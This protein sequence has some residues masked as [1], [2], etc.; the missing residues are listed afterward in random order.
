MSGYTKRPCKPYPSMRTISD[1][2]VV[3]TIPHRHIVAAFQTQSCE[4]S[5]LVAED[6]GGGKRFTGGIVLRKC[7]RIV[8]QLNQS[9][10]G[11]AVDPRAR[12]T[13]ERVYANM[14]WCNVANLRQDMQPRLVINTGPSRNKVDANVVESGR[15]HALEGKN[16][17]VRVMIS[18]HR[19]ERGIV[20]ALKS[21]R[22]PV[23][24]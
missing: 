16:R 12:F 5:K 6:P 19:R 17:P 22:Y 14:R 23:H 1:T 2:Y 15:A 3:L 4:I 8:G 21:D 20:K 11:I 18:S 13:D 24:T 10:S 7:G 9:E